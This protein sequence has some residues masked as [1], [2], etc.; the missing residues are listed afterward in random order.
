MRAIAQMEKSSMSTDPPMLKL[1]IHG[2]PHRRMHTKV[3][4]KYR[5]ELVRAC[6]AAGIKTPIDYAVDLSL[7]FID[8]TSPDY[9]NLLT[10]LYR[11]MDGQTMRE[12]RSVLTD[13]VLV[14]TIRNMAQLW[15]NPEDD[16]HYG[17]K[18]R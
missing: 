18:D 11:A 17:L 12:H 2:A 1:F 3:I 4:Q 7:L 10:A 6:D 13:D 9:D 15:S 14:R 5:E 16:P 8:P